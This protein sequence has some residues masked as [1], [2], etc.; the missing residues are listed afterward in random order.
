MITDQ[1]ARGADQESLNSGQVTPGSLQGGG[2]GA[3]PAQSTIG[4]NVQHSHA[5]SE[6]NLFSQMSRQDDYPPNLISPTSPP[7][8]QTNGTRTPD[9]RSRP[10]SPSFEQYSLSKRRRPNGPITSSHQMSKPSL[11]RMPLQRHSTNVSSLSSFVPPSHDSSSNTLHSNQ[12]GV[13]SAHPPK[14]GYDTYMQQPAAGNFAQHA[15]TINNIQNFYSD[16]QRPTRAPLF[17]FASNS[18]SIHASAPTSDS[19]SSAHS[20]QAIERVFGAGNAQIAA[21][22]FITPN[23]GPPHVQNTAPMVFT[24]EPGQGELTGGYMVNIRGQGF[25]R[26]PTVLFGGIAATETIFI[27]STRLIA[28]APP[29]LKAGPVHVV[30][31]FAGARS[32]AAFTY[33]DSTDRDEALLALRALDVKK[34]G[35]QRCALLSLT[36]QPV[37]AETSPAD[38][39]FG[40]GAGLTEQTL[41]SSL[42]HVLDLIDMDD[43]PHIADFDLQASNG[44]GLLHFGAF[45]GQ[46][47]FVSGLLARGSNPNLRDLNGMTPM[48]LASMKNQA[49]VVRK[50]RVSGADPGL[51][52]LAG[53]LP[54]DM[55]PDKE[56]LKLFDILEAELSSCK[57]TCTTPLSVSR[58]G[59]TASGRPSKG[60]SVRNERA[61]DLYDSEDD[62]AASLSERLGS[63]SL[64]AIGTRLSSRRSSFKLETDDEN[65]RT[66]TAEPSITSTD[67]VQMIQRVQKAWQSLQEAVQNFEGQRIQRTWQSFQDAMQNFEGPGFTTQFQSMQSAMQGWPLPVPAFPSSFRPTHSN[68]QAHEMFRRWSPFAQQP[69]TTEPVGAGDKV[70]TAANAVKKPEAWT[71]LFDRIPS[72][73]L[74]PPSYDEACPPGRR[75]QQPNSATLKAASEMRAHVDSVFDNAAEASF[76]PASNAS[77]IVSSNSNSNERKPASPAPP[78]VV[79]ARV[80]NDKRFLFW[81]LPLLFTLAYFL[82]GSP[83]STIPRVAEL[84][85]GF[86]VRD[87]GPPAQIAETV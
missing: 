18:A 31:N 67:A 59:S 23:Q 82:F 45:K 65:A 35:R 44:Q 10:P 70:T 20:G 56:M 75:K 63:L 52:S 39:H 29:A 30:Y 49:K 51:R 86:V 62:D 36:G 60:A 80:R 84:V 85:F 64:Q 16:P 15:T 13:Q 28:T 12:H 48:H 58:R 57:S 4:R 72:F 41:E 21:Q 76:G 26:G 46:Y 74:S 42:M 17:Q 73:G 6:P 61:P 68:K 8:S 33:I 87:F 25:A 27:D 69:W 37:Q 5:F 71:T 50:L 32:D 53:H 66:V 9:L 78:Q 22:G 14:S 19:S 40:N 43:S 1:K 47:N 24:C 81:W 3:F 34:W 7:Y 2:F 38:S 54:V 79:R 77:A 11:H 83:L 55:A